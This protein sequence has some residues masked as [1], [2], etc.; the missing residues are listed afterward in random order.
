MFKPEHVEAAKT[1]LATFKNITVKTAKY[2][3]VFCSGVFLG[4]VCG[5]VL[6]FKISDGDI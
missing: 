1:H 6:F 5:V 2:G 3:A 4:T